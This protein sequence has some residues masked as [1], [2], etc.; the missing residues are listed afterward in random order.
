[1]GTNNFTK[2]DLSNV[3]NIVQSSMIV[4][5]K[6][7]IISTLRD[8]FSHDSYYHFSK[9]QWGFPNTVDHTD[10]PPGADMPSGPGSNPQLNTHPVLPTR[11]FIGENYRYEGIF[12]PAILVKSGGTR[13]VPIS[14]NRN[15]GTVSFSKILFQDGYGNETTIYKPS[16]VVT[17]GAWE[18]TIIIDV[19]SRSLRARD[20]LVELIGMCFTEV[21][22]DTLHDI[23]IVVKPISVSGTSET[24]DRNDKLFRQTL[25][26]EIRTEWR[27]EIPIETTIDAILFTVT[28]SN[29]SQ[30]NSPVAANMT[31][32]T[33]VSILDMLLKL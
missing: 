31:I 19:L 10:L 5:P 25:T 1:M 32:N 28:F 9:D 27:R 17:S 6:E 8:F 29:L 18:G 30:P 20:D 7:M 22:F 16:A 21:H 2:S 12:Y 11:L 26:L 33:E 13:Y 15:Q 4:Y 3:Y 14:I 23:G 24:D